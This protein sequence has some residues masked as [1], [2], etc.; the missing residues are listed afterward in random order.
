MHIT[1]N[2]AKMTPIPQLFDSSHHVNVHFNAALAA[3]NNQAIVHYLHGDLKGSLALLNQTLNFMKERQASSNLQRDLQRDQ[4]QRYICQPIKS[5]PLT[6]DSM[7]R[8]GCLFPFYSRPFQ[9]VPLGD[10]DD[11]DSTALPLDTSNQ[12]SLLQLVVLLYNTGLV[13]HAMGIADTNKTERNIHF[14]KALHFYHLVYHTMNQPDSFSANEPDHLLFLLA[15]YNNIAFVDSYLHN[16]CQVN[17]WMKCFV[18]LIKHCDDAWNNSRIRLLDD[19]D[20]HYFFSTV[21]I[22]QWR[23]LT[24]APAA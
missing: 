2:T 14:R 8:L 15:V 10:D 21:G 6:D 5:V 7:N 22:F 1:A 18:D 23:P 13:Y 3:M 19:E 17:Y 4:R 9:L 16:F 24:L 20:Y 11:Q 12:D